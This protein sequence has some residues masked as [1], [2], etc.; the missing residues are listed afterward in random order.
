MSRTTRRAFVTGGIAGVATASLPSRLASQQRLVLN[1]ASRLNT[2]PVFS[3]WIAKSEPKAEFIERLRR[4]LRDAAAQRRPVSVGAARHSMGGQSLPR[5]GSAMTFDIDQC[6]TDRA[7][8]TAKVHA[9]TRWFEVIAHLD[10]IGLSPAVTQSNSDFGVASTFSVNAHGWPAPYGPF[11]TTV[12]SFRL[13]LADG[14]IVNCSLTENSELFGLAMGG[15]G[16]FGI[17]L[18]LELDVV[19]NMLLAPRHEVMPTKEFAFRFVDAVENDPAVRMVYG[20]LNVAKHGFLDEALLVTFRSLPTPATGLPAAPRTLPLSKV[21]RGMYR[22]QI[23]SESG[24]RAR[25]LAET[26]VGS[27]VPTSAKTRNTLMNQAVSNLQGHDPH[28]TDILH[29]YFVPP[30][31]FTEFVAGCRGIIPKAQADF[32]NVTLRYVLKDE[33]SVLNYAETN[34][35]AAVMS[36]SQAMTP[37]GEADML[38]LTE[39]LIDLV[40]SLGGSFYLPYRL[41]A[42]PDQLA[43]LY[44]N[45]HHFAQRK[46]HYD[47]GL[48][49]RNLMW[50]NYFST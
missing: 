15:Y 13:M 32:L 38:R 18:D 30:K 23:G 34:R 10:K 27:T 50:D 24:K 28:R 21:A 49:F 39:A 29:E 25:W 8:R 35:V 40:G 47:P 14:S 20:R 2:T 37:E 46:R 17:I 22:A 48:L 9:G 31:R 16:L 41:H 26:T 19:E 33:I 7:A 36:F 11:G 45:I 1:D 42:R 5:N 4:E 44:P 43:K 12:R 6:E 3:H